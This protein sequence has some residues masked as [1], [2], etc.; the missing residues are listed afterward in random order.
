MT[1]KH[2]PAAGPSDVLCVF[3]RH[4]TSG[5]SESPH[6]DFLPVVTGA[7]PYFKLTQMY[8]Q[9]KMFVYFTGSSREHYQHVVAADG[10]WFGGAET[11]TDCVGPSNHQHRRA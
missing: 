4:V 5:K 9:S 6:L 7:A 10:K 1:P 3:G 2:T 11:F 8:T